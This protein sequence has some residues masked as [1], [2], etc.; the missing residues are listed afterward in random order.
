MTDN[1]PWPAPAH[2]LEMHTRL[3]EGDP[4]AP[5]DFA[6]AF[7]DCLATWL[8]RTNARIDPHICDEAAEDAILALIGNPRSFNPQRGTLD[9]Y[10]RMS[11]RGDLRNLLEKEARHRSR[12]AGI[13]AVELSAADRNHLQV[14][15]DPA[16]IVEQA[17]ELATPMRSHIPASVRASLNGEEEAVLSLM[18]EG[19]RKTEAYARILGILHLPPAAQRSEVKRVKDRLKR[20]LERAR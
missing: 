2:A 20:R 10:L 16:R 4:V 9:A 14:I 6:E 11:A 5:A 18:A 15:V 17:E 19:E 7:L 13:E 3:C 8:Q 12:R 1:A